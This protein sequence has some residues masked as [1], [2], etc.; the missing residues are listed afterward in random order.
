MANDVTHI[1][2]YDI[3]RYVHV[4]INTYSGFLMAT[5]QTGEATKHVLTHC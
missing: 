5:A 4:T 3:S 2:E 1:V